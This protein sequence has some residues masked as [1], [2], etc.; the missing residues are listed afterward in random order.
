V[1]ARWRLRS[2]QGGG[3]DAA[4]PTAGGRVPN[5]GAASLLNGC[6]SRVC[7]DAR[8]CGYSDLRGFQRLL[9]DQLEVPHARPH[10]RRDGRPRRR[11]CARKS[12]LCF[13][14]INALDF[15]WA[16][17][18]QQQFGKGAVAAADV[19]PS[20]T[21]GWRQ[22]SKEDFT[23]A[24]APASHH[25]LIGGPVIEVFSVRPLLRSSR[26]R[27][28]TGARYCRTALVS[29]LRK[30]RL[31]RS[32]AQAWSEDG[33]FCRKVGLPL[34]PIRTHMVAAVRLRSRLTTRPSLLRK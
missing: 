29:R 10:S 12:Q 14:W 30:P 20:Q 7:S 31:R 23:S 24:A 28:C 22:P 9:D 13:G 16:T 25:L 1:G 5:G 2:P 21:R 19:D 4:A 3:T 8:A 34:A 18:L 6:R 15:H 27:C 33:S 32:G 17:S 11:A 26:C